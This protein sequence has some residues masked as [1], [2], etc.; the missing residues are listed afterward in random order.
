MSDCIETFGVAAVFLGFLFFFLTRIQRRSK[1][2]V[3]ESVEIAK[4]CIQSNRELL[5]VQKETNVLLKQIVEKLDK[6]I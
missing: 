2:M 3:Q 4:E 1:T 5:A 6:K